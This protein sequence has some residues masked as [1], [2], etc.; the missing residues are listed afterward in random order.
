VSKHRGAER[1]DPRRA[2]KPVRSEARGTARPGRESGARPAPP[3]APPLDEAAAA[4]ALTALAVSLGTLALARAALTLASGTWLWSLNL[5]R[6]LSPALAW[7]TWGVVALALVP[8]F[9]RRVLPWMTRAGDA[10][11]ERPRAATAAWVTGAALLAWLL[12][13]RVQFVGD[14]LLRQS[15]L[16][17]QGALP[18]LW[19]P[20][21]MPLDLVVHDALG[22]ALLALTGMGAA[23]EGRVLGAL[24]AG[25]LAALALAYARELR[26][27][28]A[29]GFAATAVL[30]FGGYL[31]LFTGY[32]KCFTEMSLV[33]AAAGLL[34]VRLARGRG[35]LLPLGLV[36]AAGALLHRSTLA[37]YPAALLAARTWS[38][39]Q[40]R[41]AWRRPA[42]LLALALPILAQAI[43]LPRM[44]SVMGD[45]DARHFAPREVVEHGFLAATL[46][47]VRLADMLNLVLMLSPVFLATLA[48]LVFERGAW[49]LRPE[50]RPL[51][52]MAVTLFVMMVFV[53]PQQGIFR[54]WDVF[55]T[56]GVALSLV[57]ALA[58]GESLRAAPSRAHLAVP[59]VAAAAIFTLQW[60]VHE[61]A[62]DRGLARVHAFVNEPPAREGNAT[63]TWEYLGIRNNRAGRWEDAAVAFREAARRLPS[64][65]ILRQ[66]GVAE[67][68]A[69]HLERA[70]DVYRLML[71]RNPSDQLA[72]TLEARVTARLD[73]LARD[74]S[75]ATPRLPRP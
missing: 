71:S 66:L 18:A 13:D 15:T 44:L 37:L 50:M 22:R 62:L 68:R 29:A 33:V 23:T 28:G 67:E 58:I 4:R 40:P 73:S 61:T 75:A 42:N 19:Y 6:F 64:P 25:A 41:G 39:S 21:A 35:T 60:L 52:L 53:H 47:P 56:L 57:S 30:F 72:G 17:T 70:R 43:V 65:N 3:D 32:N 51:A 38:I 26:L 12:P 59:V 74:S 49:R 36:L 9:S 11:I 16:Q 20:Q 10:A 27:R 8:S 69:G 34:M 45:I 54:D 7:G 48:M 31:T 5:Q 55:A 24:E 2:T 63:T 14:F 1:R 46:D